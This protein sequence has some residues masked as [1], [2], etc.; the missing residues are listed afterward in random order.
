MDKKTLT[1]CKQKQ[2][3]GSGGVFFVSVQATHLDRDFLSGEHILVSGHDKVN[4][5]V[6][7]NSQNIKTTIESLNGRGLVKPARLKECRPGTV[8]P[9]RP[10]VF[11]AVISGPF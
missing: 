1:R 11:S 5:G 10:A 2:S 4:N 7:V 8:S 6:R 9:I 3:V